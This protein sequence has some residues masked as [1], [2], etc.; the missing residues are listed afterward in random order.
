MLVVSSAAVDNGTPGR[1]QWRLPALMRRART[2]GK[3][4]PGRLG[5][6]TLPSPYQLRQAAASPG[7]LTLTAL[8]PGSAERR[9]GQVVATMDRA[10][11]PKV[12]RTP[13][14]KTSM[15]GQASPSA[16]AVKLS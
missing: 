6:P 16:T 14:A 2:S 9:G 5:G 11:F 7:S 3:P 13:C 8:V 4:G 1:D 12:L 15:S 10:S